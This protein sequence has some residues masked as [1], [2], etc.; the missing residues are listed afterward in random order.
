MLSTRFRCEFHEETVMKPSTLFV[1][2]A[3]I[4]FVPAPDAADAERDTSLVSQEWRAYLDALAPVAERVAPI[5]IDPSNPQHRQELYQQMFKGLSMAYLAYFVGDRQH[6][7]FWPLFN[8]AYSTGAANPDDAYYVA[9]LDGNGVYRISGYR[10]SVRL[11]DFQIGAGDF[12]PH[13]Q[14]TMAPTFANYD[15]DDLSLDKESGEFSVILSATRPDGYRGDW[16]KMDSRTEYVMVRQIAYDWLKEVDGRFAIERLDTPA[17]KPRLGAA[18]I[19]S[20]LQRFPEAVARWTEQPTGRARSYVKDGLVNK[21]QVRDLSASGGFTTKQFYIEGLVDIADDEALI[22]ETDVPKQ[23]RYWNIQTCDT[24]WNATDYVNRQA[25]LNG[26]SARLDS[27]G[28]FRAVVSANDPGVPN[29][30][31]TSGFQ[32]ASVFGRWLQ[33]DSQPTPTMTRVK[34]AD[35]RK[36]LPAD[37]PVISAEQ[38]DAALRLRRKG[39]QLRRR[40]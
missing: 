3:A 33:C 36:H 15:I 6:P 10:G 5:V 4:A 39:A 17:I 21:V 27:D 1:L 35:L 26:H 19:E 31:D 14:G 38:R 16:W 9:P 20:I 23:C 18:E 22:Y 34:L 24:Y 30:L 32:P 8:I 11:V 37:T 12:Y 2:L 29:W 40:W 28:K 7:D 13:G 25:S